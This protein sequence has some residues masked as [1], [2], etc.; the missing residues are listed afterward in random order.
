ML[1]DIAVL[2]SNAL[3]D[4]PAGRKDAFTADGEPA[5]QPCSRGGQ[6]RRFQK[7]LPYEAS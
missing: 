5:K 3:L 7:Q 4:T 2:C 1:L 6:I